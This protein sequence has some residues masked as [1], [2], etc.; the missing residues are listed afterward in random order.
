MEPHIYY[1]DLLDSHCDV[2]CHQ[3]NCRGVMGSGIA[4]QIRNKYPNVYKEY[5]KFCSSYQPSA[6]LGR[7]FMVKT[8]DNYIANLFGQDN[9]GRHVCQTNYDAL[10]KAFIHMHINACNMGLKSIGIPY[11]I[12]CGCAGGDWN[13]VYDII[14][15]VFQ[16]SDLTVELWRYQ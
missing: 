12:G 5:K 3:V 9:Y 15:S 14:K 13:K 6:I 7:C 8:K 16:F 1:G 11:G 10:Y 4:L 2:L